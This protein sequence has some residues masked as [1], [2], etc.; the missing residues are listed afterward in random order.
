MFGDHVGF[1]FGGVFM[2]IFWVFLV[3]AIFVLIKSF[4]GSGSSASLPESP[5]EI[6]RKRYAR[7]EI[8]EAEFE[9]HR[10]TL[11]K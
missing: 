1:G 3:V 6:L 8:T 5:L 2:W 10:K 11:E 7:G 9:Q 4:A